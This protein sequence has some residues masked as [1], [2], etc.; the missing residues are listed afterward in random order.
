MADFDPD[1]PVNIWYDGRTRWLALGIHKYLK[2]VKHNESEQN[3]DIATL[4]LPDLRR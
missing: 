2:Q 3:I 1:K 4:M